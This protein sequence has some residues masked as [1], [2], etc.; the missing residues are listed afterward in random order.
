MKTAIFSLLL[1]LPVCAHSLGVAGASTRASKAGVM[2]T[3]SGS[4]GVVVDY[5]NYRVHK[6]ENDG[7]F[8]VIGST[9][10]ADV[11]VIGAGGGAGTGGGGGGAAGGYVMLSSTVMAPG[12]YTV[13]IG[14]GGAVGTGFGGNGGQGGDTVFGSITALGG[15]FGG[16]GGANGNSGGSG[17]G[18]GYNGTSPG[19]ALQPSRPYPSTGLGNNGGAG[20]TLPGGNYPGG[21]GGG[22]GG[23]GGGYV[24]SA[25]GGAGGVGTTSDITGA[26]VDYAAGG[27]GGCQGSCYQGTERAGA[28]P[29]GKGGG[30]NSWAETRGVPYGTAGGDGFVVVRYVR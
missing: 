11:L 30:G 19:T 8:C 24:N 20:Q 3:A 6:F 29:S 16:G 9:M 10:T 26:T 1:W 17:G 12:C 23:A 5:L 21:G 27:S 25:T 7:Q 15:G 13:D 2:F 4:G 18:S 22:A 28:G 14:S